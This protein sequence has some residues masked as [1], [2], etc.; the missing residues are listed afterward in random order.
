MS[1]DLSLYL[2]TCMIFFY[3]INMII[4]NKHLA[5]MYAIWQVFAMAQKECVDSFFSQVQI[6]YCHFH[7]FL[8]LHWMTFL[9]K[10]KLFLAFYFV[11]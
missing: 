10:F 8:F 2:L 11:T 4:L 9:S 3:L 1:L 5:N 6:F 7:F